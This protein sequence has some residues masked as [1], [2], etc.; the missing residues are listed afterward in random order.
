MIKLL[1]V[2]I[3]CF[4]IMFCVDLLCRS[5]KDISKNRDDKFYENYE[6]IMKY[7][8]KKDE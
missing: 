3:V 2:I 1:I 7:N 6:K 4:T 8:E 5:Y